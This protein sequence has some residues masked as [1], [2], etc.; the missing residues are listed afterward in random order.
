MAPLVPFAKLAALAARQLAKPVSQ[1]LLKYTLT[2][3]NAQAR[4]IAVG[5]SLNRLNVRISR[6]V[7]NNPSNKR[8]LALSD[9]KALD[10][11]GTFFGEIFASPLAQS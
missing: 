2:H 8:I 3:Q 4:V 5:Q 11:G 6:L 9:E 7:D 1:I 10:A